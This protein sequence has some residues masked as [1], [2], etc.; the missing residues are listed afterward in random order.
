MK[1]VNEEEKVTETKNEGII[2]SR[3]GGQGFFCA[4]GVKVLVYNRHSFGM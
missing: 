3:G 4:F 1:H 2:Y